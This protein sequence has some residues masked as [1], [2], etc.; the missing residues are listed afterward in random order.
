MDDRSRRKQSANRVPG[1]LGALIGVI[2]FAHFAAAQSYFTAPPATQNPLRVV[3]TNGVVPFVL[4]AQTT[5]LQ[6]V[7][8]IPMIFGCN[9]SDVS[10]AFDNWYLDGTSNGL[11]DGA[12]PITI[13]KMSL[14]RDTPASQTP[15]TF[16]S[17]PGT[18]LATGAANVHSDT[19]TANLPKDQ[20]FWI[21]ISAT[22]PAAGNWQ[23]G[24]YTN[25]NFAGA[26]TYLYPPANNIDQVY[27]TGAL[28]QPAQS[29]ATTTGFGPSAILGHCTTPGNPAVIN[30]GASFSTGLDDFAVSTGG[31]PCALSNGSTAAGI[32][33]MSRAALNNG[34]ISG[35][36]PFM[37]IA[38]GG[39]GAANALTWTKSF[40]YFQ[41]GNIL[42][43]DMGANDVPGGTA[44]TIYNNNLQ[45]WQNA[46]AAGVQRVVVM[47]MNQR[48]V[49]TDN[50]M[51][52]ANQTPQNG[53]NTGQVGDQ[54]NT[55]Y[56]NAPV[57]TIDGQFTL[58]ATQDP[59]SRW[60]WL[61]DGT[62]YKYTCAGNHPNINSYPLAGA[63]LRSIIQGLSVN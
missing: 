62:A 44:S 48:T 20:L 2:V 45:V 16:A 34:A 46:R 28:T 24:P 17:S 53:F 29:V 63:E 21:R 57:G 39:T 11:L 23:F 31:A 56:Q 5:R 54:L 30:L 50:W 49:S 26:Q 43:D 47:Q 40:N 27:A 36:I 59:T 32:G 6:S 41:Y 22:I 37:K 38:L 19:L 7:S 8:R 42:F 9:V 3:G 14:E 51:T 10:F 58:H 35:T 1:Q 52:L 18:T 61:T 25:A 15:I 55:L 12:Q 13:V 33:M 60:L 4:S